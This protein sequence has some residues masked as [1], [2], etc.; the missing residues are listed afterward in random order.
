VGGVGVTRGRERTEGETQ[1]PRQPIAALVA[2]EKRPRDLWTLLCS[3]GTTVRAAKAGCCVCATTGRTLTSV[4]V[5]V[6]LLYWAWFSKQR[7]IC[8]LQVPLVQS[9]DT[10]ASIWD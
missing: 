9:C 4:V 8:R 5:G 7:E 10:I 6:R 2:A 1:E 3:R